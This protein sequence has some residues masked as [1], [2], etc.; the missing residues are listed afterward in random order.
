[1]VKRSVKKKACHERSL[2][3]V[4]NYGKLD[5]HAEH[6]RKELLRMVRVCISSWRICSACTSV[7]DAYAQRAHKGRSIRVRKSIF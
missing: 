2:L 7:P 4:L 1:M 6:V 3:E 5:A